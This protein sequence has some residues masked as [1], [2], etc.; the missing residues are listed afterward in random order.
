[1]AQ[2]S[3]NCGNN[4]YITHF[5]RV[6]SFVAFTFCCASSF[7]FLPNFKR[8]VQYSYSSY[9]YCPYPSSAL[10]KDLISSLI[11]SLNVHFSFVFSSAISTPIII[12]L[13]LY[14][15]DN[16]NAHDIHRHH[17]ESQ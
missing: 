16:N 2:L 17:F 1:M 11:K 4:K 8:K 9:L 12:L 6:Y 15:Y 14:I 10:S 3:L 13:T 5:I 7:N